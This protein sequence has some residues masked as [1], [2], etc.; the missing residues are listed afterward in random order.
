MLQ[1]W[2]DGDLWR[3]THHHPCAPG[4]PVLLNP[5]QGS[6]SCSTVLRGLHQKFALELCTRSLHWRLAPEVCHACTWL[7]STQSE[8]VLSLATPLVIKPISGRSIK[9]NKLT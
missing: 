6:P 7:L 2:L 5:L 3:S 1:L 4:S 9:T 8:I